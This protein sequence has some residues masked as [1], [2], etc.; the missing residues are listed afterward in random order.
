[1]KRIGASRNLGRQSA[2][3]TWVMLAVLLLPTLIFYFGISSSMALGTTFAAAIILALASM[4]RPSSRGKRPRPAHP[5]KVLQMLAATCALLTL[6]LALASF[7][8]PIQWTRALASLIPLTLLVAGA[9]ALARRLDDVPPAALHRALNRCFVVLCIIALLGS[10]GV[11]PPSFQTFTKPVFPFTEPSHFALAFAPLLL[12]VCITASGRWRIASLL[13]GFALTVFLQN[14]TLAAACVLATLVSLQIGRTLLLAAVLALA[15]AQ[16][17]LT[18]FALRLDFGA[19]NQ[20]LSTLVYLQGWQLIEESWR[21]SAGIGLGFQQ[22]GTQGTDVDAA[23][24]IQALV[25]DNLNLLD[26]GFTFA[27][28]ASEFGYLGLMACAAFLWLTGRSARALQRIAAHRA[29]AHPVEVLAHCAIVSYLLEM[30]VRGAGYFTATGLLLAT[31]LWLLARR[32]TSTRQARPL[33]RAALHLASSL[34]P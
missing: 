4:A 21:N 23:Q 22:L 24:L 33:T 15:A 9:A 19:E 27:K 26:G 28:L 17:D 2:A 3:I 7:V 10:A 20:N 12:Y 13:A 18:Y 8:A 31:G 16:L 6:H 30:F 11:A 32:R 25:G 1:M 29:A 5:H 34:G 14:L